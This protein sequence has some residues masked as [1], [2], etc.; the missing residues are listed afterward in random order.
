VLGIILLYIYAISLLE[1]LRWNHLIS[2]T[3][4]LEMRNRKC[5]PGTVLVY[6]LLQFVTR[7]DLFRHI[8]SKHTLTNLVFL[9]EAQ[10]S[11]E[12]APKITAN[13]HPAFDMEE[14][15]EKVAEV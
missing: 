9:T 1:G 4:A 15:F 12:G 14:H 11:D 3:A 13:P 5:P 8:V 6:Q 10:H 2:Q 7:A